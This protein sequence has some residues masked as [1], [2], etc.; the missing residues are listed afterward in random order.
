AAG[1]SAA[2]GRRCVS[3]RRSRSPRGSLSV[4]APDRQPKCKGSLHADRR[5]CLD[6]RSTL[7]GYRSTTPGPRLQNWS[8]RYAES[9]A[10]SLK[11]SSVVSGVVSESRQVRRIPSGVSVKSNSPASYP[12]I[13]GARCN[14][15]FGNSRRKMYANAH[16]SLTG[17]LFYVLYGVNHLSNK[18]W[19]QNAQ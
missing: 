5:L 7:P 15:V 10:C 11:V 14:L 4:L 2:L 18:Y 13:D 12:V 6:R 17:F 9:I 16:D 3:V 19:S 8:Q 1:P